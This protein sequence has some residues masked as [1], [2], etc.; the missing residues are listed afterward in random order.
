[1]EHTAIAAEYE[2][3]NGIVEEKGSGSG[4]GKRILGIAKN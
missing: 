1:L 4:S 2:K 3:E